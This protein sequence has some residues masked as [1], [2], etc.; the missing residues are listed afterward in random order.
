M[1]A[2]L[3]IHRIKKLTVLMLL[4]FM[5][6][7]VG[8]QTLDTVRIVS[9]AKRFAPSKHI[10]LMFELIDTV[11]A[12]GKNTSMSRSY[13]FDQRNRSI[14]SVREYYNPK[15]PARGTQ[16]IY[17]FGANKLTAVTVIPPRSTCRNCASQYYYTNDSLSSKQENGQ[18][19]VDPAIFIKQARSFQS[20]LPTDL[21]WG[22]FDDEI[23]VN[24]RKKK[25]KSEY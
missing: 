16:V 24:G 25:I 5:G 23:I 13:Y 21:P 10:L 11:D 2:H 19:K 20:K 15:K 18:A 22:T 1:N 6:T 9:K 12:S 7:Y 3:P 4:V 8:A 14:S 17:S